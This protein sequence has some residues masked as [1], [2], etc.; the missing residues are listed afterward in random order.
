MLRSACR[1][2]GGGVVR[3]C[4]LGCRRF[5]FRWRGWVGRCRVGWGRVG[6]GRCRVGRGRVRVGRGRRGGGG[7]R[8][9]GPG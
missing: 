6:R 1:G 8:L 2:C 7:G 5:R 9:A 4:L 3:G